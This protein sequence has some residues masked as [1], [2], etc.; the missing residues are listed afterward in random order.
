MAPGLW[1]VASITWTGSCS[2]VIL[3]AQAHS[4]QCLRPPPVAAPVRPA[5]AHLNSPATV[6]GGWGRPSGCRVSPSATRKYPKWSEPNESKTE[7]PEEDPKRVGGGGACGRKLSN[8]T[9]NCRVGPNRKCLFLATPSPTHATPSRHANWATPREQ[10]VRWAWREPAG[11]SYA[12]EL[13]CSF[14]PLPFCIM[15][16]AR[17]SEE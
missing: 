9:G 8:A 3:E 15:V 12:A 16:H 17:F 1:A 10:P 7:E 13:R 2:T 6:T 14:A 4:L 11:R 5:P